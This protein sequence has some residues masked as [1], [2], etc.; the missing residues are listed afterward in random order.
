[1]KVKLSPAVEFQRDF[2]GWLTRTTAVTF[3]TNSNDVV[4]L[5]VLVSCLESLDTW[6]L[7]K[8]GFS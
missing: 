2:A 5:K 7:W 8:E 4:D 3:F 6:Y 1:M